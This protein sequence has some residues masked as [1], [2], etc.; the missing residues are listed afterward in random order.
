M[1]IKDKSSFRIALPAS[2]FQVI[3][4]MIE[5]EQ[6][7][8]FI[9][10]QHL[11]VEGDSFILVLPATQAEDDRYSQVAN[12][13]K[14]L[15]TPSFSC[16]CEVSKLQ[17]MASNLMTLHSAN[18]KFEFN[19]KDGTPNIGVTFSTTNGSASD[20]L[21]VEVIKPGTVKAPIE[22]KMF[23]DSLNLIKGSS[24]HMSFRKDKWLSMLSDTQS[25]AVVTIIFLRY[26]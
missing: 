5:G 3:D 10:E 20:V 12:Y 26:S 1:K 19:T 11:K 16:N 15:E 24:V 21:K 18:T 2:H 14:S 6:A 7:K 23:M 25:G 8:F 17:L 4:K 22:P 9:R 13:V